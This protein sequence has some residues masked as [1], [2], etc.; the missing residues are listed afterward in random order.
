MPEQGAA[1]VKFDDRGVIAA[2]ISPNRR[3]PGGIALPNCVHAPTPVNR[4]SIVVV[5]A[6]APLKSVPGNR[7]PAI[8]DDGIIVPHERKRLIL[9]IA[10]VGGLDRVRTPTGPIPQQIVQGTGIILHAQHDAVGLGMAVQGQGIGVGPNGRADDLA[11][12]SAA[13]CPRTI[14][15]YILGAAPVNGQGLAGYP[16]KG[17]TQVGC[18]RGVK[19]QTG[20]GRPCRRLPSGATPH[21]QPTIGARGLHTQ[22]QGDCS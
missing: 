17:H 13:I 18:S 4:H 16:L 3:P 20:R 8:T 22:V 11:A 7:A 6:A 21:G 1:A 15:E 19:Q 5:A 12:P 2:G 10:R 9:G 14:E